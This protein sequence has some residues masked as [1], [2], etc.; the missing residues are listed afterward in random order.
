MATDFDGLRRVWN[1]L[2]EIDP[3]WAVLSDDAKKGGRWDVDEFFESGRV[4]VDEVLRRTDEALVA[5][6]RS[7][8]P[9]E[10]ALDFGCG[11]GRI[12]Q[13]LSRH[14]GQVDGVDIAESMVRRAGE[15]SR[16]D[17]V[18][19]VLSSGELLEQFDDD[20]FDL[21]Y[22]AHVLQHMEPTYQQQ[23]VTEFFR[24]L[25]DGG[26]AMLEFVTE[27]VRGASAAL[28]DEAFRA[29]LTV[30]DAPTSMRPSDLSTVRVRLRNGGPHAW[31]SIGT[32][33]WYL[34]TLGAH[35]WPVDAQSGHHATTESAE[36]AHRAWL[37]TD[38]AAGEEVELV[39]PITAPAKLGAYRLALD[40]VQEGVDW[41]V[42]RGNTPVETEVIRV[43]EPSGWHRTA[44]AA[45]RAARRPGRQA[46]PEPEPV[47]EMHGIP[48]ETI[49]GWVEA[50]G[51]R[52][53]TSFDWDEVSRSASRDWQRRGYVC[54]C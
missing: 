47:M 17:N 49:Q 15:L 34:V 51:G 1:R 30:L 2:G 19:F 4:E 52:V 48:D 6:G 3:L 18:R 31:P 42:R 7:A 10:R 54:V 46:E 13:G 41:F 43:G 36:E 40:P 27:P 39:L 5:A 21:V 44:E 16:T 35:W 25:R 26:V 9:R 29:E 28:P 38:L 22:T 14:V 32:D 8:G 45:R 12:S 33:G 20:E 37:P 24:V 23:Y 11:V 53:L 50:A